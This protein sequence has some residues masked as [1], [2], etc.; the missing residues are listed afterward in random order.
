M[1]QHTEAECSYTHESEHYGDLEC[2]LSSDQYWEKQT[3]AGDGAL[4]NTNFNPNILLHSDVP[5]HNSSWS[6]RPSTSPDG[7]FRRSPQ[8][9]RGVYTN[10][11]NNRLSGVTQCGERECF[12]KSYAVPALLLQSRHWPPSSYLL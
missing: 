1:N 8:A 5:Q 4:V 12:G 2:P 6:D 3:R 10:S 11:Y 7:S 9:S